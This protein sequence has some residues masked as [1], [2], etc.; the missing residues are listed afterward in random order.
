[1]T[2]L[3][4]YL[5]PAYGAP[6]SASF[7]KRGSLFSAMFS[8]ARVGS[9]NR[10]MNAAT[11]A[12]NTSNPMAASAQRTWLR[13]GVIRTRAEQLAHPHSS[14][15]FSHHVWV[16]VVQR[17]EQGFPKP[18]GLTRVLQSLCNARASTLQGRCKGVTDSLD[19]KHP[20]LLNRLES[21]L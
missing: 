10:K 2:A 12:A 19:R 17:R 13:C 15:V 18:R 7:W 1:M 9:R 4:L 20:P 5:S 8:T 21:L 16:P 14:R 3:S 6:D 11:I